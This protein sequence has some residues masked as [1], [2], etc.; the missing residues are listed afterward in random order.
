M[1]A[2]SG[3]LIAA[4]GTQASAPTAS[5]TSAI[6]PQQLAVLEQ[7]DQAIRESYLYADYGG[8]NW[9]AET[10]AVRHQIEAGLSGEQFAVALS[11]LI[12]QLPE[13]SASYLSRDERIAAD[14][15][16]S[17]VYEG[18]G[19]FV[20]VRGDP[21]PRVVLLSVISGSPAERSGLLAHDAIYAVDG[22]AVS[23]DEG[24]NVLNRVRGP[25]GS[26]VVLRVVSPSGASRQISVR[27]AQVVAADTLRGGLLT[28][29]LMYLLAPAAGDSSI[30]EAVAKV[31][32]DS[33]D[34]QQPITG[35]VLDL[36][37]AGS[38]GQWPLV[39][40]LILLGDGPMGKFTSRDGDQPLTVSGREIA[41]SQTVPLVLLTGPDTSGLPEIFAAALQ[42]GGRAAVVGLPSAG[43]VLNYRRMTLLDGSMLT[44]ADSTY[45]TVG[46]V[47]LS[48]AGVIPDIRVEADWDEVQ[49]GDDP[50]LS[51]ALD[52]LP[53]S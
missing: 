14:L 52:L 23:A 26:E 1:L 35:M 7:L 18:I 11:S 51:Q 37:I 46:G 44:F 2:A 53:D 49:P 12:A 21:N 20:G 9:D 41:N 28:P 6:V 27:R 34:Q 4:C 38:G 50:V 5:P 47:D 39:E 17:T 29:S 42:A 15:Q 13:G 16:A 3:A 24:V 19:A 45:L 32:Q 31:F 36:R 22:T 43:T 40:M 8:L 48:R 30:F 10:A 25:A 33:E